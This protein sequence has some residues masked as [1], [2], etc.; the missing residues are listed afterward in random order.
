MPRPSILPLVF[1]AACRAADAAG[2]GPVATLGD[3][4]LTAERLAEVLVLA[5]PLPLEAG[6][7]RALAHHW[8]EVA[9]LARRVEEGAPLLD[10]A[11]V[12]EG[13]RLEVGERLLEEHLSGDPDPARALSPAA[14]DSIWRAGELRLVGHLFRRVARGSGEETRALQR[15]AAERLQASL[16]ET[17]SLAAANRENDDE[18]ARANGGVR[19]VA[20][21][22][23]PPGLERVAWSLA[24]GQLSRVVES[25]EGFHV[26]FRPARD[27]A[28]PTFARL[29][30]ERVRRARAAERMEALLEEEG[31]EILPGAA[32]AL[33]RAAAAPLETSRSES[34]LAR[35]DGGALTAGALARLLLHLPD[36]ALAALRGARDAELHGYF[37]ELVAR[38]VLWRRLSR[39]GAVPLDSAR[40]AVEA[41]YRASLD[42][43]L[44]R[45][46][47]VADTT[48][49]ASRRPAAAELDRWRVDWYMDALAARRVPMEPLPPLLAVSLLQGSS[50]SVDTT[51]VRAA[52]GRAERLLRAAGYTGPGSLPAAPATEV[53]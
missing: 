39:P 18:V 24:P 3:H 23:M 8:L 20:P 2:P 32:A 47:L 1:L 43:A 51:A 41:R 31:V 38:D 5:Q 25:S 26:L 52:L 27:V 16:A 13:V 10:P 35:H 36:D 28:A 33:R 53:R 19:L 12:M 7:A 40:A 48:P 9:A 30:G 6:Q 34:V 42:R 15:A 46:R 4:V 14:L 50:W 22:E 11:V 37:E 49:L 29:V 45:I 21:G 44:A 17:G